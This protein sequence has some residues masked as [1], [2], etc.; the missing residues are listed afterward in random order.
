[1]SEFNQINQMAVSHG[2]AAGTPRALPGPPPCVPMR[3]RYDYNIN[4][5]LA[6]RPAHYSYKIYISS[7]S[8][9]DLRTTHGHTE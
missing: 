7:G 1:M 2:V 4:D 8:E 9:P 6:R 5:I 3:S